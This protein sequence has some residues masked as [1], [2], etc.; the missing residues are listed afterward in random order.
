[1]AEAAM[2]KNTLSDEMIRSGADVIRRL[3]EVKFIVDAALWFYFTESSQ[4]HLVLASPEVRLSGPKRAYR[5][6]QSAL[7]KLPSVPLQDIVILDSNDPL[8][9]LLKI[10][11]Q[12]GPG[13]AGVRFSRNTIN[14]IFVE[15]AYI[16]R[17]K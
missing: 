1:M 12:T 4:W 11:I 3:D 9:A 5:Q 16:Y 6:V 7:K 15:D 13:I 2:V 8:I 14:G 17:I 10:A